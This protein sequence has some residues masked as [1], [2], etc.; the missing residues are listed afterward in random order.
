MK[1][2]E[3]ETEMHCIKDSE[4]K[5]NAAKPVPITTIE[6]DGQEPPQPSLDDQASIRIQPSPEPG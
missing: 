3:P 6:P 5:F 1:A 2:Y 4:S